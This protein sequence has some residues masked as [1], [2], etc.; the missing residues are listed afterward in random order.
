MILQVPD[1][2]SSVLMSPNSGHARL[3]PSNHSGLDLSKISE[4]T[5]HFEVITSISHSH[6]HLSQSTSSSL[7]VQELQPSTELL[8]AMHH[9]SLPQEGTFGQSVNSMVS[10]D[11]A[12]T[13]PTEFTNN[14]SSHFVPEKFSHVHIHNQQQILTSHVS[15]Q[16]E[17][18]TDDNPAYDETRFNNKKIFIVRTI[19]LIISFIILVDSNCI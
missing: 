5:H 12:H 15:T 8:S 11:S 6:A 2:H 4:S 10:S 9:Y 19:A 17:N 7:A 1:R 14:V 3:F 16:T 13:A 18:C